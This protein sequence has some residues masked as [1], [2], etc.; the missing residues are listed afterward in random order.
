MKTI[1]MQIIFITI[2][3]QNRVEIFI[4]FDLSWSKTKSAKYFVQNTRTFFSVSFCVTFAVSIVQVLI[5]VFIQFYSL[6]S[7]KTTTVLDEVQTIIIDLCG[8]E[9]FLRDDEKIDCMRV[10]FLIG[11]VS[12]E[13][14]IIQNCLESQRDT[15]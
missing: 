11:K 3:F 9:K 12:F 5:F 4:S 10:T 7:A 15:V 14:R 1:L 2:N 6:V 8:K 13:V